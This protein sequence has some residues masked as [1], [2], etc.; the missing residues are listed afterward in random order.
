MTS[1]AQA[2]DPKTVRSTSRDVITVGALLLAPVV[3]VFVLSVLGEGFGWVV[4]I[5]LGWLIGLVLLRTSPSWTAGEKSLAT[6]V[7]PGGLAAPLLLMT[8]TGEVCEQ[9]AGALTASCTGFSVPIWIGIP[10]LVVSAAALLAVAVAR[11]SRAAARGSV[12]P[13]GQ[14]SVRCARSPRWGQS[15]AAAPH[16]DPRGSRPCGGALSGS[17]S[18][19]WWPRAPRRRTVLVG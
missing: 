2:S 14:P 11:L 8:F 5:S 1:T 9:T 16:W 12:A 15:A 4:G 6:L 13:T 17:T 18:P 19:S 7:W 3:L 10:T